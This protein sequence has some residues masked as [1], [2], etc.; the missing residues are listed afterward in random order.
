MVLTDID[1]ALSDHSTISLI[2]NAIDFLQIVR[3]RDDLVVS[4]KVL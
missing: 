1:G 4:E 3:V 2:D